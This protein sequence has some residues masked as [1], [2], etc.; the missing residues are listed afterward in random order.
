MCTVV[1]IKLKAKFDGGCGLSK[2]ARSRGFGSR[3]GIIHT[4]R[5]WTTFVLS[6]KLLLFDFVTHNDICYNDIC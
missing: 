1:E 5:P 3:E 6:H 4:L 2:V